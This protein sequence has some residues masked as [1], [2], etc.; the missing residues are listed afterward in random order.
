MANV[1][2]APKQRYDELVKKAVDNVKTSYRQRQAKEVAQQNNKSSSRRIFLMD[3]PG[4]GGA[5]AL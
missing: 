2:V 4:H 1:A 3:I 5:V